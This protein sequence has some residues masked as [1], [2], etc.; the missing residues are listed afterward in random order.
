MLVDEDHVGPEGFRGRG[1]ERG[2]KG[3]DFIRR[4]MQMTSLVVAVRDLSEARE[5]QDLDARGEAEPVGVVRT[6]REE[7]GRVGGQ[8]TEGRGD[9][10][11]AARVA[12]PE[13]V[14]GVEE[15]PCLACSL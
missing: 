12:Q 9:G 5:L 15:K 2:T 8:D 14:V 6:R 13:A 7:D 4:D 10:E 11:A 1:E 3:A